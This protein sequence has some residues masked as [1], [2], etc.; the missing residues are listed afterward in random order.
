MAHA[1]QAEQKGGKSSKRQT[2]GKHLSRFGS[3][4]P[5]SV[6]KF[7][8]G[9]GCFSSFMATGGFRGHTLDETSDK[10]HN[11]GKSEQCCIDTLNVLIFDGKI[12]TDLFQ[13][14]VVVFSFINR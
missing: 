11:Q 7:E 14:N 8:A 3:E 10:L 12:V 13:L 2:G 9:L 6:C 1:D 5:S 4:F